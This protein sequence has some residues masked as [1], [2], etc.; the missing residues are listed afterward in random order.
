MYV[1][2][3]HFF[4]EAEDGGGEFPTT[5]ITITEVSSGMPPPHMM[6]FSLARSA[7]GESRLLSRESARARSTSVLA[8]SMHIVLL[9]REEEVLDSE[10]YFRA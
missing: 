6:S 7:K 1:C 8:R 9:V 2:G 10:E 3:F 4:T 5:L